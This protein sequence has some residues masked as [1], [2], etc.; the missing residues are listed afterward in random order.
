MFF[1]F[2]RMVE[3]K[4][5]NIFVG[6]LILVSS[7]TLTLEDAHI[8]ERSHLSQ[9]LYYI[10][11]IIMLMFLI[12][13]SI[14]LLAKG[15]KNFCKSP[16]CLLDLAIVVCLIIYTKLTRNVESLHK[17]QEVYH[18]DYQLLKVSRI[19][20]LLRLLKMAMKFKQVKIVV[21][22]VKSTVVKLAKVFPI[23]FSFWMT[24]AI[25][26]L[27]LLEGKFYSCI[28]MTTGIILNETVVSNK[29]N[30]LNDNKGLWMNQ[31]Y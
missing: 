31:R 25:S 8:N 3:L 5:F 26:G 9:S 15:V 28:D 27:Y 22:T 4:T 21:R 29:T 13:V 19:L 18:Q 12:E 30:C 24:F 14:R 10:D 11:P 23:I 7:V 20:R 6:L 2:S 16:L 17:N 1:F